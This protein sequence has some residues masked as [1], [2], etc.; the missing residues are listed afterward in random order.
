MWICCNL[1]RN[2]RYFQKLKSPGVYVRL[3][4][5]IRT[6]PGFTH[7]VDKLTLLS[8]YVLYY[9]L[10]LMILTMKALIYF[11]YTILC[12]FSLPSFFSS[13]SIELIVSKYH[14]ILFN[15]TFYQHSLR[16]F[17]KGH[18]AALLFCEPLIPFELLLP[19]RSIQ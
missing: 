19:I 8:Y 5:L 12:F 9:K 10:T 4:N 17:S 11:V 15:T 3:R 14:I 6:S 16:T 18:G 13:A 2:V 1:L 7:H